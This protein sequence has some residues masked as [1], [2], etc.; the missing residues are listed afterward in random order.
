[1]MLDERC[2]HLPVADGKRPVGM[3]STRD[4]LRISGKNGGE[5]LSSGDYGDRKASEI[6]SQD[7][8][9]IHMDESVETAI[10]RIGLGDIHALVV[11]DDDDDLVGIVTNHDLLHYLIT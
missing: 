2:H 7:L 9:T 8:E 4:L 5:K 11:V 6:M 3:I 10:D 1:M